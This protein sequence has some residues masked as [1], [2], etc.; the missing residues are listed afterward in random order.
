M[1][2]GGAGVW[3]TTTNSLAIAPANTSYVVL[4]GTDATTTTSNIL[5][6]NGSALFRYALT[7][8]GTFTA[9][10]FVST[11]TATSTF[12]G[13]IDLSGGCLAMNGQCIT[14]DGTFATTSANYWE[15]QQWRW[16]TSSAQAFEAT[17]WRW[18]TTSSDYWKSQNDFFSTTSADA[19]D[20]TQWH[21]VQAGET[22]WKIAEK[23]YGDGSLY[24]NIFEANK[25][26]L[27]DPN[28]IKVGQKLRIP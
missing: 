14:M 27:K 20:A 16:A 23:Y 5:E 28:L 9:P 22:L 10:S 1:G 7:A 4:V 2:S 3:S 11:S 25:D 18:S 8:Y 6:V 15:S 19:W 21:E 24:P 13:G 26:V 12:A 17:Q